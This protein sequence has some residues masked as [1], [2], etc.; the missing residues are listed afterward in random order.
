MVV[1]RWNRQFWLWN[2]TSHTKV[3]FIEY[4]ANV[5]RDDMGMIIIDLWGCGDCYRP[6]IWYVGAQFDTLTEHFVH[7]VQFC[8]PKI[9]Q[10]ISYDSQPPF[11]LLS[12]SIFWILEPSPQGLISSVFIWYLRSLWNAYRNMEMFKLSKGT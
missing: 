9:H 8:L 11:S 6:K 12:A 10:E 3:Y 5:L 2:H 4:I 7:T 1:K